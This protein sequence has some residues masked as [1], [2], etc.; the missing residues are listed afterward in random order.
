MGL[1]FIQKTSSMSEVAQTY[2]YTQQLENLN[3][4]ELQT[5]SYSDYSSKC[6]AKCSVRKWGLT[7]RERSAREGRRECG[8]SN[9]PNIE[10]RIT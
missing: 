1:D 8:D 3:N 6:M 5:L 9:G 10:L 4:V 2:L 7:W